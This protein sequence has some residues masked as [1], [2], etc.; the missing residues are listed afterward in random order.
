MVVKRNI[1]FAT[2]AA[3]ALSVT[4]AL[5]AAASY[6]EA[7]PTPLRKDTLLRVQDI[8]ARGQ[9]SAGPVVAVGWRQASNPA[10]LFLTFS[11]DGGRDYRRTNGKLRKYPILGDGRLGMSLAVCSGRV[12]AGSAFRNPSDKGGDSDVF[13]TTRTVGGGADQRFM[14]KPS[15]SRK[16]RNVQVACVGQDLIAIAW[17]EKSSGASRAKLMLRSTEPL[18]VTPAFQRTY[19]LGD[20]RFKDG[21]TVAAT[22]EAVHVAWTKGTNRNV[23]L[24]RFL[25]GP[26]DPVTIDPQP[27]R[28][29]SFKDAYLPQLTAS[30]QRVAVAYTDA[31]KIKTKISTDLGGTY[32]KATQIVGVGTISKPSRA[33]SIDMIGTRIV[34]EASANRKGQLTPRRIQTLNVGSSW[35][36]RDY[37]HNGARVGALMRQP[38]AK[39]MLMEAWHNNGSQADTVRASYEKP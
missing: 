31:G 21:I 22:P 34:V 6:H 15:V 35:S 2:V 25:V 14:T 26:G 17:L 38:D 3:L 39:P 8:A 4:A 28:T 37:G 30:G 1:L 7:K 24:K 29:I 12:W 32:G 23:R 27:V 11:T 5:P 33:H 36:S 10:A 20:G 16:A 13:L 9:T 19:K 18:S